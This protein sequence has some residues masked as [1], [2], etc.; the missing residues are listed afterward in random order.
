MDQNGIGTEIALHA[1]I[2]KVA[3]LSTAC[4]ELMEKLIKYNL[5]AGIHVYV[6]LHTIS[7]KLS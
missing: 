6:F 2:I 3:E 4:R 1:I 7:Y 5:C